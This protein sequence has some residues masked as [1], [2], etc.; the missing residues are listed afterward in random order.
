MEAVSTTDCILN[1]C[2]IHPILKKTPYELLKRKMPNISCF[3]AFGSKWYT[4]N[5]DKNNLSKFEARS[6]DAIFVCYFIYRKS[7]KVYNKNI[8]N[9]V[10]RI[11]VVLIKTTMVMSV[12]LFI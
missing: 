3:R 5:N 2:L 9:V 1:R 8:K 6:C 10:E 12:F 11:H 7:Y 4:H